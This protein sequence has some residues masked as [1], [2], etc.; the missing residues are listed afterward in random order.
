[1]FA[2]GCAVS[3][4]FPL[5]SRKMGQDYSVATIHVEFMVLEEC[6]LVSTITKEEAEVLQTAA[7]AVRMAA[8]IVDTPCNEMNVDLFLA[9]SKYFSVVCFH[10]RHCVVR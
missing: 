8:R 9:V 2:Y 10:Y 7:Y 5:F 6:G 3:R 4:A 1:M